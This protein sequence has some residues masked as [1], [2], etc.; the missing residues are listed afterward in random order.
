MSEVSFEETVR[1]KKKQLNLLCLSAI[2]SLFMMSL[3]YF[4]DHVVG[5]AVSAYL[6]AYGGIA[7][8][9]VIVIY[10]LLRSIVKFERGGP[11]GLLK[12]QAEGDKGSSITL[13]E[14]IAMLLVVTLYLAGG[15]SLSQVMIASKTGDF[16]ERAEAANV[17]KTAYDF[18][19]EANA[20]VADLSYDTAVRVS[21]K[22]FDDRAADRVCAVAQD[23]SFSLY[24]V[25]PQEGLVVLQ[26]SKHHEYYAPAVN[27]LC[28]DA[29]AVVLERATQG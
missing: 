3:V 17:A 1:E 4:S 20:M 29:V 21:L 23:G 26:P 14:V 11:E 18:T 16:L 8:S 15:V 6:A 25:M 19:T 9:F 12:R 27:A 28:S 5:P 7:A 13:F 2:F 22:A 10:S 24:K